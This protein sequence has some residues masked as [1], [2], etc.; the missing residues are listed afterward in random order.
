[1]KK[2]IAF[3]P[4]LFLLPAFAGGGSK[5]VRQLYALEGTWRMQTK[6]GQYARSGT[7]WAKTILKA[8]GIL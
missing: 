6:K 8:G 7:R 5:T 4:A 3:L 2:R 1:M